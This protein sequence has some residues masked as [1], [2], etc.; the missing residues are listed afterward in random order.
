[1]DVLLKRF[2]DKMNELQ[3]ES[4]GG[5]LHHEESILSESRFGIEFE[6]QADIEDQQFLSES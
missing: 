1:M 3:S 4:I 5:S 6:H 2:K